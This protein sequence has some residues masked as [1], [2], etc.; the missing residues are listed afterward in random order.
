M[1]FLRDWGEIRI[2]NRLMREMRNITIKG[3]TEKEIGKFENWIEIEKT[4]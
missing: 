2:R 1:K 3:N 4:E